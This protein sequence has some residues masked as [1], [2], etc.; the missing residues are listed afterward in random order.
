[1]KKKGFTLIELLVVIAIIA[2][3]SVVVILTLNPADLLRQGRDATRLADMD[4][5][6]HAV[7]LYGIDQG[8]N[9]NFS[10]GP[11]NVTFISLPDPTATTT[12][13]TDCTGIGFPGAGAFHCAA[14]STLRNVNGTGWIPLNFTNMTG[15]S[16]INNLPV[17]PTNQSSTD[18]Y[19]SYQTDGT[20]FKLISVPESQKYALQV[21]GNP[22]LFRGGTNQKIAGGDGWVLVPGNPTFNTSNFW[23]MKYDAVCSDG[24][25]HPVNDVTTTANT[26]DSSLIPCTSSNT[27]SI[28]SFPG[29]LPLANLLPSSEAYRNDS[30][31]EC[32]AIGSHLMTNAEWQTIA[33]NAESQPTNWSLNAVGSG[34]LYIGHSDNIPAGAVAA[35]VNDANN[36][37]GTDGPASCGG[38]GSNISQRRTFTLSNGSTLWDMSGNISQWVSDLISGTNEPN[39]GVNAFTNIE[40]TAVTSWGT[41]GQAATGPM[42][43]T[44]NSTR[45]MGKLFSETNFDPT[46]YNFVRGGRGGLENLALNLPQYNGYFTTIGF[47]CSR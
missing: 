46:F 18:V 39:G 15:G 43:P 28:A 23:A 13:G 3:L 6:T 25:G 35:D 44:W 22:T 47:R 4:T 36:C 21:G 12:A 8:G 38:S 17:D 26:Y 34:V 20:T 9:G 31:D 30:V 45:N 2:I 27:R 40:F 37:A 10:L 19:Y 42:N 41:L 24:K 5:L 11:S 7:S 29:G 16:P 1:M 33:W 32:S 14:S